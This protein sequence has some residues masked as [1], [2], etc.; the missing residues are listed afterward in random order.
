MDSP[1]IAAQDV[2]RSHARILYPAEWIVG[3]FGSLTAAAYFLLGLRL[4]SPGLLYYQRVSQGAAFYALGLLIALL[5][6]RL[7]DISAARRRGQTAAAAETIRKFY[8]LYLAPA[9]LTHDLRLVHAVAAMFV[10][11]IELKNIVPRLN[12]RLY[13][14]WFYR[15]ETL[16]FGGKLLGARLLEFSGAAPLE[17]LSQ[18]Y[19]SFYPYTAIL[20]FFFILQRNSATAQIFCTSFVFTWM[21]GLLL[22]IALPTWGP[23][24]YKPELFSTLPPGEMSRVQQELWSNKQFLDSN[25]LSPQGVFLISGFPS[26]HVAVLFLGTLMLSRINR[27]LFYVS[28]LFSLLT[29]LSTM[30]FGW[31]YLADDLAAVPLVYLS[32]LCAK[33]KQIRRIPTI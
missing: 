14:D 19:S 22:V 10:V 21:F 3:A 25:P 16:A 26:L 1:N 5:L 4:R 7:T 30:Y 8:G 6:L 28:A 27:I 20:V 23:C 17:L 2:P 31:H 15:T 18:S 12:P 33:A 29:V 24:F 13:D 9:R 32:L 11:F